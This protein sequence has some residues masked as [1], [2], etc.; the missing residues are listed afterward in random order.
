M[1]KIDHSVKIV[2]YFYFHRGP[3]AQAVPIAAAEHPEVLEGPNPLLLCHGREWSE[4]EV[5]VDAAQHVPKVTSFQW[6]RALGV[7]V[8]G[9][10][11]PWQFFQ[12][13]YPMKSNASTVTCTND[14]ILADPSRS[15]SRQYMG[16]ISR[17]E[18]LKY[19]GLRLTMALDPIQGPI[20]EYW[21]VNEYSD[22]VFA[23]RGLG[24]RFGMSKNR[25]EFIEK[26]LAFDVESQV[27]QRYLC[28]D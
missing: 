16:E 5:Q 18:L 10:K 20:T 14:N 23:P 21:R 1:S 2:I 11:T 4:E 15:G 9:E 28:Y 3:Q 25:F 22:S 19:I 27:S 13:L 26:H 12:L 6:V 8:T 24:E 7:D 17:G